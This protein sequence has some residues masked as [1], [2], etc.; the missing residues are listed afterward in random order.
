MCNPR[1]DSALPRQDKQRIHWQ[2]GRLARGSVGDI[3]VVDEKYFQSSMANIRGIYQEI[4]AAIC[5]EF[6]KDEK[7][8]AVLSEI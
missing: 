7:I 4:Y 8:A 5:G 2:A 6:G 1:S 3:A